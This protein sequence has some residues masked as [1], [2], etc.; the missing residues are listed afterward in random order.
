[1]SNVKALLFGCLAAVFL[2]SVVL[3]FRKE[4]HRIQTDRPAA[5]QVIIMVDRHTDAQEDARLTRR[6]LIRASIASEQRWRNVDAM[7][8]QNAIQNRLDAQIPVQKVSPLDYMEPRGYEVD[9]FRDLD[10]YPWRGS[11]GHRANHY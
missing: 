1:M 6:D 2:A 5:S 10:Y 9:S 8:A 11:Y 3:V 7:I 4:P